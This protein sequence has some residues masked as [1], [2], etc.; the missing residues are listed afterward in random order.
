MNVGKKTK[1]IR[2]SNH[3]TPKQKMTDKKQPENVIY[4][5]SIITTDAKC[6]REINSRFA[7]EKAAFNKKKA[8]FASK[9]NL[10]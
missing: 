3:P 7:M 4:F 8:L 10:K 9:L 6:T 2:I 5:G 1:V